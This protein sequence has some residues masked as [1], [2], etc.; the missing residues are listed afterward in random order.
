MCWFTPQLRP[1]PNAVVRREFGAEL[2]AGVGIPPQRR[3]GGTPSSRVLVRR[4]EALVNSGCKSNSGTGS[5]H[6]VAI[7]AAVEA[8]MT[9]GRRTR[10]GCLHTP[11]GDAAD[12][13][14]SLTKSIGQVAHPKPAKTAPF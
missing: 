1:P 2:H 14:V 6:S 7:G 10:Y 3:I 9:F 13:V 4:E 12:A 5:L 11:T 8:V